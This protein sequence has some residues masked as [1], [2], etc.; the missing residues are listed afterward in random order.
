MYVWNDNV[1]HYFVQ[2]I[3]TEKIKNESLSAFGVPFKYK[4]GSK[5]WMKNLYFKCQKHVNL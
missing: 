4:L 5:H 3:C 1:T 2:L